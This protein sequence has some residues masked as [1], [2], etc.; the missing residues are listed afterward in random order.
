MTLLTRLTRL[1]KADLHGLLEDLE[2]P[3]EVVK[4]AMRDMEEDISRQEAAHA[5]L[6]ATLLRLQREAQALAGILQDLERQ[7][8]LCFTAGNEALA[9]NLL[10]KRLETTRRA[11]RVATAQDDVR[12]QHEE[13]AAK[14]TAHK[15][16]LAAIAQQLQTSLDTQP[17]G[18]PTHEAWGSHSPITDDEIEIAF[19]EEQRRR[20]KPAEP[21]S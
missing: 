1:L 14:I 16:Q 6:A 2:E 3:V 20:S 19:L 18:S 15:A 13:L 5:A 21:R 17:H 11:Q 8:D 7:I 9:R 10:R 12:T 4:Q